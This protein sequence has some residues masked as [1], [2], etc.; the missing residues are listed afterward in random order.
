MGT[1]SVKFFDK[2]MA[3]QILAMV[4]EEFIGFLE[5]NQAALQHNSSIV[6]PVV[7]AMAQHNRPVADTVRRL[8]A[9]EFSLSTLKTAVAQD[10]AF[11]K[12]EINLDYWGCYAEVLGDHP[13]G[14]I[15]SL[16][17]LPEQPEETFLLLRSEHVELMTTS[18]QEHINDLTI[19]DQGQIKKLEEWSRLCA[20][21][22]GYYV[23]YLFDF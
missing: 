3:D 22:P 13:P 23:A 6:N 17:Y 9:T 18:L 1:D 16:D 15:S 14:S 8:L 21:R 19:M 20:A 7:F 2:I 5:E 12:E 11:G 4:Q 10:F